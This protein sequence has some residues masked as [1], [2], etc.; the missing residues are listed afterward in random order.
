MLLACFPALLEAFA[1]PPVH[2]APVLDEQA[3]APAPG[4]DGGHAG[5]A[6]PSSSGLTFVTPPAH[7]TDVGLGL[8]LVGLTE[9]DPPS[10]GFPKFTGE[11]FL[12]LEWHDPRVGALVPAD[13]EGGH[14]VFLEHEAELMLERIWWPDIEFENAQGHRHVENRELVIARDGKVDYRERFSGVFRSA[15]DLRRFPFDTQNFAIEIESFAWDE[16]D[17]VFHVLQEDIGFTDGSQTLE[18]T[19]TSVDADIASSQEVRSPKSFSKFQFH[20]HAERDS[21]YYMTKVIIPLIVIIVFNWAIFWMPGEPASVRLERGFVGLLTV[22]AFHQVVSQY[23]PRIGY[24]TFMDAIVYLAFLSI[25][26][27]MLL[28]MYAQRLEYTGRPEQV[29]R[30]DRVAQIAFPTGLVVAMIVLWFVYHG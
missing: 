8:Y 30:M 18:W 2:E 7:P 1:S 17:L 28:T 24:M 20:I 6:G 22:V 13:A 29:V 12:E 9:V 14:E 27:T 3:P 16:D 21:G 25:G 19:I 10:E 26:L 11:F 5:H 15:P 4:H 23:L